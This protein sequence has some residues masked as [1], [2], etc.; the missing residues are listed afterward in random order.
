[1]QDKQFKL[2]SWVCTIKFS[3]WRPPAWETVV[4]WGVLVLGAVMQEPFLIAFGALLGVTAL[5]IE[6]LLDAQRSILEEIKNN[7]SK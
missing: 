2:G 7:G 5:V 1:M 3:N 4:A 6:R